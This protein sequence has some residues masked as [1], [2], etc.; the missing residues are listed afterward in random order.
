M[1]PSDPCLNTNPFDSAESFETHIVEK[2]HQSPPLL[3]HHKSKLDIFFIACECL[4]NAQVDYN[5]EIVLENLKQYGYCQY[6]TIKAVAYFLRG[7]TVRSH[8][9]AEE[10]IHVDNFY[11]PAHNLL[12]QLDNK[13]D[14]AIQEEY[15]CGLPFTEMQLKTINQEDTFTF[16]CMQWSPYLMGPLSGISH[17]EAWNGAPAKEFRRSILDGDYRYCNKRLCSV[18]NNPKHN[19]IPRESVMNNQLSQTE[20]KQRLASRLRKGTQLL[21]DQLKSDDACHVDRPRHIFIAYDEGCNLACPSCRSHIKHVSPAKSKAMDDLFES[22]VRPLLQ[23]GSVLLTASGHGDP[24]GSK[25][26]REKLPTLNGPEYSDL[27]IN[28]QTNGLLLNEDGWKILSPIHDKLEDVRV[29]IDAGSGDTYE[30][31]RFPGRWSDLMHSLAVTAE[32]KRRLNFRLV[33]NFCIQ[34][35][36]FR[37]LPNFLQLGEE[38]GVDRINLQ[39]LVNWGTYSPEDFK[40]RNVANSSHPLHSE[41]LDI[42]RYCVSR[43]PKVQLSSSLPRLL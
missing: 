38:L 19:M 16:C 34:S 2:Y 5:P 41:F 15:I 42:L 17:E 25:H 27:K 39:Q 31:V 32:M 3:I 7:D 35:C 36:N 6:L 30:V 26:L 20:P 1:I 4:A 18:F 14:P 22:I 9:L 21:A 29:S 8:Q 12:N 40:S 23:G 43:N 11:A 24:L 13:D 37:E 10:A 28:L 33:I